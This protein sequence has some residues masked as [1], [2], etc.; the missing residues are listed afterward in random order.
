MGLYLDIVYVNTQQSPAE[1][2]AFL[3][4]LHAGILARGGQVKAGPWYSSEELKM[5]C[6]L[7]LPDHTETFANFLT[8]VTEKQ[9]ARRY[10]EPIVDGATMLGYL[11]AL[12]KRV[13]RGQPWDFDTINPGHA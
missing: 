1:M 13:E 10:I 5:I 11:D 3:R 9:V 2:R 6:V 4:T 7:E 12:D 8:S